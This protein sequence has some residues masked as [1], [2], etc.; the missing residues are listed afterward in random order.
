[1]AETK[2]MRR[3]GP[4]RELGLKD[5][6]YV[7][8]Q[9]L[10][11]REPNWTEL[12]MFS[13][14]WSEHCAYKHSKRTL[15]LLPTSGGRVLVGPGENAGVVDIGHGLA[16][17]FKMES[18]NHP[19]AVE[20]YQGA[21]TGV[22]GIIR[23]I[24]AMGARP[25]ALLD[26]LRFGRLDQAWPRHI[27]A[28]VVSG[29]AGY[30]N[31]TGLPTVG[32]ET[33]FDE[34]YAHNPLCNVMCLGLLR[35]DQI[36]RG[37]AE[38]PGNLVML[39]GHSTGRDG[40]HGC[41]FASEELGE[42]DRRPAVQV[43]DPWVEKLLI[44][45]CL[46]LLATGAVVGIQDLGAAGITSACAE[47]A[48]R[49][50]T[51]MDLDVARVVRREKGMTPYEVLLSESQ[52]R[53]LLIVEPA[54]VGVVEALARRWELS[55]ATIGRVTADGML[56]VRAG[57]ELVAAIP[58][59]ALAEGAPAYEPAM[60][61]PAY[62]D[63]VNAPGRCEPGP[64]PAG[65]GAA[66]EQLLQC[67]NLASKRWIFRQYDHM[68]RTSTVEPPGS[69]AGVLRVRGTPLG[70]AV[71]TDGNG[72]HTY[73]DPYT[74]GAAA[75]AEAARNVVACGAQPVAITNCLNFG[76]PEKPEISWQFH[77]AVQGMAAACRAL[78]TPVTG[79]NVSFYN[80]TGGCP[81]YPTPIV[82]MVGLL[83]DVS[84][85]LPAGFIAAG[86][87]VVLLGPEAGTLGGSEYLATVHGRVAGPPPP[88]DLAA[89]RA[90]HQVCLEL[91]GQGKL[92]SSHDV[93]DGG[94]AV[95]L[96]ECCFLAAPGAGGVEVCLEGT[97]ADRVLFGEAHGRML[98]SCRQQE[99]EAVLGEAAC[100]GVPARVLGQV[101]DGKFSLALPAA[102]VRL[103]YE[104]R[105]LAAWWEG[106]L[107]CYMDQ[108]G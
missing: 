100:R 17:A 48:A 55:C 33:F 83:E 82:G 53:M 8:I 57:E 87:A 66:L 75:V 34:G 18:H 35:H 105:Q 92:A 1:L 59:Q 90:L 9:E 106:A 88:V 64:P 50:G 22:G 89:E 85:R 37:V 10:L 12:G 81:V 70:I 25:M 41:T 43:G 40:I 24:L 73:L 107:S 52:E 6:E 56:R 67:P 21:A 13:V 58:A 78:G 63:E 51:G 97:R 93:S 84:R 3:P 80:E 108:T 91:A 15:K 49:A 44:E 98:V 16:L 77:Q 96:A 4:W 74:G 61:R 7:R 31:C 5:H 65:Y 54:K 69:D 79:G 95:A 68:V 47:T 45:A 27:F 28:G 20:P 42:A 71:A 101:V 19:I 62:L 99:V 46:E 29:I 38:G 60:T 86:D 102:G 32:G 72:R 39:L 36:H 104:T 30:A 2:E 94:L 11:G 14:L 103:A 76:N 26:S 23:D